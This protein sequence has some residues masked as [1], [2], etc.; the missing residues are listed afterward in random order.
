[1]TRFRSL[2]L[3][4]D[5]TLCGIE[6]I[7]WLASLRDDSVARAISE[8]TEGAMR[9]EVTL[10][11]IYSERLALVRPTESEISVLGDEYIESIAPGAESAISEMKAAGVNVLLVSG[12]IREA[13]LPLAVRLKIP[14]SNV[15]AVSVF[16]D[17]AGEYWGFDEMAPAAHQNGKRQIV[18]LLALERPIIAVGDGMTDAEIRPAVD[19]FVAF[20]G[21]VSRDSVVAAAERSVATFHELKGLVLG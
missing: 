14:E 19:S 16:F 7:D 4:V 15:H 18:D 13:I 20:T 6:G 21:F 10:E 12:G 9:G 3:D 8:L 11:S 5:S 1:M 2:V 17:A